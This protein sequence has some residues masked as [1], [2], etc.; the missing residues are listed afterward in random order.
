MSARSPINHPYSPEVQV[1][2]PSGNANDP[3]TYNVTYRDPN[4]ETPVPAPFVWINKG[5]VPYG[6]SPYQMVPQSWVGAPDNYSEGRNYDFTISITD[7]GDDY[8]FYFNVSDGI[9]ETVSGVSLAPTVNC[10]PEARNPGVQGFLDGSLGIGHITDHTPLLNWSFFDLDLGDA[11]TAYN[12][13]V[14][15]GAMTTLLWYNNVSLSSN[16]DVYNSTGTATEDLVDG[17]DYWLR[18]NLYDGSAWSGWTDV[19]FHMNTPPP[20]PVEPAYPHFIVVPF[21]SVSL[22]WTSGGADA[23]GDP[24]TYD[25]QLATD[26]LFASVVDGSTPSTMSDVT[27][28]LSTAYYW[29][30]NATD[31]WET[32]LYGNAS[33]GYWNFTTSGIPNMAPE[34]LNPSVQGFLQG[35]PL[36][37]NLTNHSPDLGWTFYDPDVL[38]TQQH[39]YPAAIRGRGLDRSFWDWNEHVGSVCWDRRRES[40]NVQRFGPSR[41][42]HVLFQGKDTRRN[43]LEPVERDGVPHE[44]ASTRTITHKSLEWN[45]RTCSRVAIDCLEYC[46]RSRGECDNVLLVRQHRSLLYID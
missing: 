5:G 37:M 6:P 11:Q 1:I 27:T 21:G 14:W 15:D 26:S 33:N 16:N 45:R 44:R 35:N 32:S 30:V 12:V 40:S 43:H 46:C 8:S 10:Q 4:N 7:C 38:D 13:T 17:T 23:E 9:D 25:W 18:V 36:K 19:M 41:R 42:R 28:L 31:G 2:P 3:F 24:A 22:S 39:G 34:A 29:R 20:V